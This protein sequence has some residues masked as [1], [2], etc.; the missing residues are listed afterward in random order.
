MRS[1]TR[2]ALMQ[3]AT[4]DTAGLASVFQRV[5]IR[6]RIRSRKEQGARSWYSELAQLLL[7][8]ETPT[9]G[10]VLDVASSVDKADSVFWGPRGVPRLFGCLKTGDVVWSR[11]GFL[12]HG[13]VRGGFETLVGAGELS[14]EMV[15][16]ATARWDR[17]GCSAVVKQWLA[18]FRDVRL[19]CMDECGAELFVCCSCCR[20]RVARLGQ[21]CCGER[22]QCRALGTSHCHSCVGQFLVV[23]TPMIVRLTAG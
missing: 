10:M 18:G 13:T 21:R 11:P 3:A 2:T 23:S 5:R 22:R 17:G 1:H 8:C 16:E 15:V 6:I 12:F 20:A 14:C 9:D 19:S 7:G 4:R